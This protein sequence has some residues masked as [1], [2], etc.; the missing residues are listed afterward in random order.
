MDNF[1]T[2]NRTGVLHLIW[3]RLI[4]VLTAR[5]VLLKGP[6][7]HRPHNSFRDATREQQYPMRKKEAMK[8]C[9]VTYM[10]I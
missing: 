4:L 2:R 9:C 5:G 6:F 7:I 8:L 3:C 10:Y 1:Q